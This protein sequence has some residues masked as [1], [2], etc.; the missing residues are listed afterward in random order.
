MNLNRTHVAQLKLNVAKRDMRTNNNAVITVDEQNIKKGD[1]FNSIVQRKTG[2]THVIRC[3]TYMPC[4]G[5]VNGEN[6]CKPELR[7][8]FREDP[9]H[10][11]THSQ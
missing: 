5:T 9:V 3:V 4:I 7:V 1:K 11:R 8:N 10:W 2:Y 6:D